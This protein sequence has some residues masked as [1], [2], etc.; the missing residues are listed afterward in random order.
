MSTADAGVSAMRA[1]TISREYGSG[2]G[3]IASRLAERLDWRL[4]DHEVVKQIAARLGVEE[5]DAAAHDEHAESWVMQFLTTMQGVG[6]MV[7]LPSNLSF[8]P[9][10]ASYTRALREV[11]HGAVLAGQS[12]IVGRGSQIILRNRRDTLHVRI[13]APLEQRISYVMLRENLSRAEAQ[14]RITQRDQERRRYL[15]NTYRYAPDDVRLYDITLNTAVLDLDSCVELIVRA[16]EAKATQLTTPAAALGPAGERPAPY[17][18]APEDFQ[19][20]PA[21]ASADQSAAPVPTPDAATPDAS[22]ES[23]TPDGAPT[24][25]AAAP[26]QSGA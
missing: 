5:E 11:V 25:G 22:A 18:E 10:E 6:P 26:N 3:E 17:P 12:V 20:A 9:T 13:V 4:V 7:A 21:N 8:P 14:Q 16:L 23:V 2:G 1:I 15:I 24:D 19:V